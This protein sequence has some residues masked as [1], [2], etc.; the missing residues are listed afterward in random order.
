MNYFTTAQPDLLTIFKKNKTTFNQGKRLYPDVEYET[1]IIYNKHIP[2]L[3]N[4]DTKIKVN[5]ILD[6]ALL[7]IKREGKLY[8]Y[9]TAMLLERAFII[10]KKFEEKNRGLKILTK[11][12]G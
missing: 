6:L 12:G 3:K 2:I 5:N 7:E 8:K 1:D 10:R 4:E 9:N 11:K